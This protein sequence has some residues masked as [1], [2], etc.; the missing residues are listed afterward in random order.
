LVVAEV[1]AERYAISPRTVYRLAADGT[2]PSYRVGRQLRFDPAEVL[3]ALRQARG[4]R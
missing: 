4:T 2:I 1:L 3:A